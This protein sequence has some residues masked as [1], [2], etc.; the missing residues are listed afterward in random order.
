[1]ERAGNGQNESYAGLRV[2]VVGLGIEGQDLVRFFA[3]RGA[4]VTVSDAKP[5]E[6]LT[7]ALAAI[8]NL[9]VDLSLG[10]NSAAVVNGAALIAVSQGVPL[11]LPQLVEARRLGI[12]LTTRTRLFFELCRGTIVGISGSSGKTTTTSL[13]GAILGASG[14][15]YIVGGNIGGPLLSHLEAIDEQT[16]AVLEI[17]HTQLQM[18][19]RSPHIACL[20]NVTPNHLDQFSWDEYVGLKRNLIAYQTRDDCCVLN[21]DNPVTREFAREANAR[22]LFFSL[23][24]DL[25]GDGAL[26]R[27]GHAVIRRQGDETDLFPISD[28]PLR[29]RHNVENVLAAAAVAEACDI[30]APAIRA[31]VQTFQ[32]VPHRLELVATVAGVAYVNDSIATSPERTLAGMRSFEEPVVLLLGGRDKH[33]PLEE[34]AAEAARRCRAVI[35]FGEAGE[36]LARACQTA[37][38]HGIC[39]PMVRRVRT[40]AEAVTAATRVACAGDVV[41]LSPACTSF[42]AYSNFEERGGEFRSLVQELARQEPPADATKGGAPSFLE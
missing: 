9:D 33:L 13:V 36:L 22:V 3:T 4:R 11:S 10:E 12:P 1:M 19:D 26:L 16:W 25:P 7:G 18:T 39:A 20:T 14:R 8:A 17:S 2:V 37:H 38:P 5:A 31:A 35:C 28:I 27:E 21:L 34:L 6:R 15:P 30:S 32:A 23:Q 24:P 42:D 41:L 40:M 29:G